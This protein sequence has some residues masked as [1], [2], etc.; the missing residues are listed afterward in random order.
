MRIKIINTEKIKDKY[1][2]DAIQEYTKRLSTYCKV[3]IRRSE[4]SD[5]RNNR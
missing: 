3:R 1:V 5:P 2:K 4:K